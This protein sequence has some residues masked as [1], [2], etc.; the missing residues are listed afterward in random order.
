M[1]GKASM[2][3]ACVV[4]M[5][6]MVGCGS[7]D[8]ESDKK[9][10]GATADP[11]ADVSSVEAG[12][13]LPD[14]PLTTLCNPCSSS[15]SCDGADDKESA[16]VDYG[17]VGSFCGTVC[18]ADGDCPKGDGAVKYVCK[19]VKS[20]EGKSIKQCVPE[21]APADKGLYGVCPCSAWAAAK[22]MS[23]MCSVDFKQ[24][25]V[26]VREGR[27]EYNESKMLDP[28]VPVLVLHREP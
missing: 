9:K 27:R 8:A 23:T 18:T 19:G 16:C 15:L 4:V 25:K 1:N 12:S 6:L 21:L 24:D 13:F 11:Y 5:A 20:V 22:A 7:D 3:L 17:T 26:T 28:D 14:K 10:S 2:K